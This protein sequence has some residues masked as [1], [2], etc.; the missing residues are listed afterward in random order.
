[1]VQKV[2]SNIVLRF[3]IFLYSSRIRWFQK[4][5][6]CNNHHLNSDPIRRDQKQFRTEMFFQGIMIEFRYCS[7]ECIFD[8]ILCKTTRFCHKVKRSIS[9]VSE[10]INIA[11]YFYFIINLFY[12]T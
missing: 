10:K 11:L 6:Q 2:V 4:R 8:V 7:D 9:V 1:M 3:R 12:S 5:Q